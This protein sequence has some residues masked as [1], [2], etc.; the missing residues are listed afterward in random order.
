MHVCGM[1]VVSVHVLW[2]DKAT[3]EEKL[4]AMEALKKYDTLTDHEQRQRF[5]HPHTHAHTYTLHIDEYTHMYIYA[6]AHACIHVFPVW[7]ATAPKA[8][9]LM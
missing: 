2:P 5:P 1:C 6:Y 7:T 9:E 3:D 8:N 4:E